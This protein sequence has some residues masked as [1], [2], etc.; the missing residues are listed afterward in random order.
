MKLKDL[1]YA[2]ETW[3]I[4]LLT[5]HIKT[6]ARETEYERLSTIIESR[7]Y[8][9]QEQYQTVILDEDQSWFPGTKPCRRLV[10]V[11]CRVNACNPIFYRLGLQLILSSVG[12]LCAY[13]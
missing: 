7:V 4:S 11:P 12:I 8:P 2:V 9:Q 3:T 13:S 6:H 10:P 1:G 5:K